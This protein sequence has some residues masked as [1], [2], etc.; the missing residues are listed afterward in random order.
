MNEVTTNP[1]PKL[2]SVSYLINFILYKFVQSLVRSYKRCMD[3]SQLVRVFE[4][5]PRDRLNLINSGMCRKAFLLLPLKGSNLSSLQGF[6]TAHRANETLCQIYKVLT[7]KKRRVSRNPE[8]AQREICL[9]QFVGKLRMTSRENP[10][11]FTCCMA[12]NILLS[13]SKDTETLIM[14]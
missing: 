6:L 4:W 2:K 14:V 11:F 3:H 10:F 9:Y 12:S 1:I 5:R 13:Y 8:S 7:A